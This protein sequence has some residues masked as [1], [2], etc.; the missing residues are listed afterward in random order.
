MLGWSLGTEASTPPLLQQLVWGRTQVTSGLWW[1]RL[2]GTRNQ[3]EQWVFLPLTTHGDAGRD[4]RNRCRGEEQL[5]RRRQEEGPTHAELG[6][7]ETQRIWQLGGEQRQAWEGQLGSHAEGSNCPPT[8]TKIWTSP[9]TPRGTNE[10][11]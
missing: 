6:G 7:W 11:C 3:E 8:P 10:E 1:E 5:H 2:P 4:R 9:R